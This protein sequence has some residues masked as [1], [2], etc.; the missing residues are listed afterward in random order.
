MREVHKEDVCVCGARIGANQEFCP[1]CEQT[2][3][4]QNPEST[5]GQKP[6]CLKRKP[7]RRHF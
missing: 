6:P 4:R 5:K 1:Q 2:G 3:I 7:T